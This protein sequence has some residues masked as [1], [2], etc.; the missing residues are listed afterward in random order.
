[1]DRRECDELISMQEL[2]VV[3]CFWSV[4]CEDISRCFCLF[5]SEMETC[6]SYFEQLW[7]VRKT[8]FC[9]SLQYI[10]ITTEH[11]PESSE[12]EHITHEMIS[13]KRCWEGSFWEVYRVDISRCNRFC[14]SHNLLISLISKDQNPP[15]Q[16]T[17][18]ICL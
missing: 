13:P 7:F 18:Q 11:F 12:N 5:V 8:L 4:V 17:I 14:K 15:I 1:M 10:H 6:E 2:C 9:P 16:Q 3:F